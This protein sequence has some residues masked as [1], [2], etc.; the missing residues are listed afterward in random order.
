MSP[1]V[2]F[3][4]PAVVEK[5]CRPA[6]GSAS[7]AWRNSGRAGESVS[8]RC[9]LR[10]KRQ[11][12]APFRGRGA[13]L[14]RS[15]NGALLRRA[16]RAFVHLG[17]ERAHLFSAGIG[18]DRFWGLP[19]ARPSALFFAACA[20]KLPIYLIPVPLGSL[21]LVSSEGSLSQFKCRN[22]YAG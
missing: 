5:P 3:E 16:V 20:Q 2:I 17:P 15:V 7:W 22:P 9:F 13:P 18:L 4:D 1:G 6:F 12:K 8:G 21:I 14:R 10:R 11:E 19:F